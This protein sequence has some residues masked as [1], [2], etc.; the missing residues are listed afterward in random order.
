MRPKLIKILINQSLVLVLLISLLS[1][2]SKS[3][4]DTER[5][6]TIRL[7]T[8]DSYKNWFVD[9]TSIDDI[10]QPISGCDSSYILTLKID[11][12]WEEGYLKLACYQLNSGTW[13]LDEGNTVISI[14]F[15]DPTSGES[16]ERKFEII[17]LSEKY[18][19]YQYAKNNELLKVRLKIK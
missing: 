12:S 17:A 19:E 3:N 1:G 5:T 9:Q 2:C 14:H 7:L 16:Q 4:E 6:K 15:I 11:F 13:M 18:F 10:I 8:N